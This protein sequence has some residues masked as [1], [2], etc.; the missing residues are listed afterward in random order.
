MLPMIHALCAVLLALVCASAHAR[1]PELALRPGESVTVSFPELAPHLARMA[2]D[3][4]ANPQMTIAL[5][6]DYDPTRRHPLLIFLG[7]GA[8]GNGDT[9]SPGPAVTEGQ[10]FV[11]VRMPLFKAEVAPLDADNRWSRLFIHDGDAEAVWRA[12]RV[13]LGKLHEMVPNADPERSAMGGFSNGAN[14]T[15]VLLNTHA[16]EL[17]GHVGAFFFIEGGAHLK[18]YDALRDRHMLL[19]QGERSGRW[20]SRVEAKAREAGAKVQHELMADV[21]HGFP[22]SEHPRLRRWLRRMVLNHP[23]ADEGKG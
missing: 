14:T 8:G 22:K 23:A 9:A 16:E 1:T 2:A 20:L 19:L 12:Y 13:M 5:P 15:A 6:Q 3:S 7:G 4:K 21:G 11:C 18:Q 10:D 17:L